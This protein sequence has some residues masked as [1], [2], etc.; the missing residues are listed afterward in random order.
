MLNTE[1]PDPVLFNADFPREEL[2]ILG[3]KPSVLSVGR[4]GEPKVVI[5][6]E[7]WGEA[8]WGPAAAIVDRIQTSDISVLLQREP[9]A[10]VLPPQVST[11]AVRFVTND[12]AL[13]EAEVDRNDDAPPVPV[14][15]VMKRN[16]G[17]WQVASVR[18]LPTKA[19]EK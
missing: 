13:V 16:E 15:I 3:L 19:P 9:I 8:Q 11:R 6:K 7:P 2:A 14:L 17:V 1:N 4:S 12:V 5:S 10:V 18:R